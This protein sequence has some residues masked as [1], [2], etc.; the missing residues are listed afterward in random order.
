LRLEA[1]DF[2]YQAA[3]VEEGGGKTSPMVSSVDFDE[4]SRWKSC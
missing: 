3:F 4:Y 1:G 2:F